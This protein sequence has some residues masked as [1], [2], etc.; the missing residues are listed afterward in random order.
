M[1]GRVRV[2][3]RLVALVLGLVTLAAGARA[4]ELPVRSWARLVDAVDRRAPTRG[5]LDV[6]LID[7]RSRNAALQRLAVR[8]LGQLERP[9]LAR[10]VYP[11]LLSPSPGVRMEA[12]NALGQMAQSLEPGAALTR[13]VTVLLDRLDKEPDPEVVGVLCRTLGRLPYA[14][15]GEVQRIEERLVDVSR[16]Q[17]TVDVALGVAMGLE[18]LVRERG[19]LSPPAP[20]TLAR[21]RALTS[22]TT[23]SV[24]SAGTR[25]RRLAL[26][27]LTEAG[28]ADDATLR[29]TVLDPDD[30]V[31][32]ET[33]AAAGSEAGLAHA[34]SLVATGLHDPSPMVRYEALRAYGRRLRQNGCG[35]IVTA[36]A[37]ADEQVDLLALDLLGG[38]CRAPGTGLDLLARTAGALPA[39]AAGGDWHRPVHALV[40]LARRAPAQAAGLL[41]SFAGSPVWEVRM[42]AARAAGV[43]R[44]RETLQRLARDADDNVRNAALES[45]EQVSGHAADPV[46]LSALARPDYQLVRTAA[47]ALKGTPGARE[48][49]PALLAALERITA[50]HKDTSRDT[51]LALLDR[52][53][54]LGSAADAKALTPYVADFD[55]A[56]AARAAAILSTWT[57]RHV[58]AKTQRLVLDVDIDPATLDRLRS[59]HARVTMADGRFFDIALLTTEAPA[60]VLRFVQLAES[61]YYNGLTFHRVVPNFV[62]QGGSPGANEYMG[63]GAFMP[64]EVGLWPHVRGAVGISTRGHD[65]GD[66][67]IFIDLVDNPR[68]DGRYTVF[69]QVLAGMG[70]VDRILEGDVIEKIQVFER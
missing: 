16:R 4:Q 62:I 11:H 22:D 46:Y 44:D 1:N 59:P 55:P 42:Y 32:R 12:A 10:Y 36:A 15:A 3:P 49:V 31:R 8:A 61:G 38:A 47:L 14:D 20:D 17:R 70:T 7:A 66:G 48:A 30:Q 35:P 2:S 9:D 51:R 50:G 58:R 41:P 26:L 69:G 68:L 19:T 63:D 56:V 23:A 34:G 27:A 60:T 45:L 65:T 53:A 29:Q 57:R 40:S 21:L 64:D 37:D 39:G 33:M 54:E 43:L 5:D 67:Q 25:V 52:L 18:T 24:A 6:L 13:M 28:A